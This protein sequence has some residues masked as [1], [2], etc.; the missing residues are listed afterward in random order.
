MQN[1]DTIKQIETKYQSLS[2]LMDERMRRQW[3]ASEASALG[4]GGVTS[5]SL[6]TGMSRNTI[7]SG[8]CELQF[9]RDHPEASVSLHIRHLG[10]GRKPVTQNDPGL[11]AALEALV[12]PSTRGHPQSPLR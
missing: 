4:W 10:G 5:V 1:I 3:A 11:E 8:V 2:D 12:N 7:L 6:A 9:R